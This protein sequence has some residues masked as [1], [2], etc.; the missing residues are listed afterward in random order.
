MLQQL[1]FPLIVQVGQS[2]AKPLPQ[3][4]LVNKLCWSA[5]RNAAIRRV[6]SVDGC[7]DL[8][9]G[10]AALFSCSFAQPA[11]H[12]V[13]KT[14]PRRESTLR[15][16]RSTKWDNAT[17]QNGTSLSCILYGLDFVICV[18]I[19]E[20]G[21]QSTSVRTAK[22]GDPCLLWLIQHISL[23]RKEAIC[24]HAHANIRKASI[25]TFRCAFPESSSVPSPSR[26]RRYDY[27]AFAWCY[28]ASITPAVRHPSRKTPM[29]ATLLSVFVFLL[30]ASNRRRLVKGF[31][32][33]I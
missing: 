6:Y 23:T 3:Q 22:Y 20:T 15:P 8:T 32:I 10:T 13:E 5:Q 28:P 12:I 18:Q 17:A 25:G 26:M 30:G 21:N 29:L 7:Q 14:S 11:R 9:G 1:A 19:L 27:G 2:K 24:F 4:R 16:I 31:H 33:A